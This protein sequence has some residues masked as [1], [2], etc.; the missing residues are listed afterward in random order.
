[1]LRIRDVLSRIR[2]FSHPGSRIQTF[3]SF[4][5]PHPTWKKNASLLFSCF[6]WF[7]EQS[8]SLS[9]SQKDPGSGKNHLRSEFR[10]QWVKNHLIPDRDP[11]TD[12]FYTKP[13]LSHTGTGST[14]K[15]SR[16]GA[17]SYLDAGAAQNWCS[18]AT[19]MLL[20][21]ALPGPL[22]P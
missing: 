15:G 12:Y 20:P 11:P 16:A 3:F 17:A 1:V 2:T 18:S 10:I 5:I 21:P 22:S 9:L 14:V 19:L 6:L 7:Q 4:R 13:F 8:I